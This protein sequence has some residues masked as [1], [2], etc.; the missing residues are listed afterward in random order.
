MANIDK[1]HLSVGIRRSGGDINVGSS[2]ERCIVFEE[3]MKIDS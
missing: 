3:V 2:Q 1:S